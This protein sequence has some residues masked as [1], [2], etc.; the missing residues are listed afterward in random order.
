M[1]TLQTAACVRMNLNRSSLENSL[2]GETDIRL[3]DVGPD[4]RKLTS[5][6]DLDVVL[7][8]V[9]DAVIDVS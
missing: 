1:A 6:T 4:T 9:E 7:G 8:I 2:K 3:V 5:A